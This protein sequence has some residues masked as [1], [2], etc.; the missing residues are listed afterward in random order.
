MQSQS[1]LESTHIE[2]SAKHQENAQSSDGE[3][4]AQLFKY[5]RYIQN[6]YKSK[7]IPLKLVSGKALYSANKTMFDAFAKTAQDN[8]FN[9]EPYIKYCVKCGMTESTLD[10]CFASPTMLSKYLA[11]VKKFALRKKIYRWFMKSAKNIAQECVDN[12]Y[13][14]TKDF[15]RMLIETSQI[16]TYVVAGKISLYF[17]AALPNFKKAIPKLDHFSQQELH[18]LDEHF[19]IYHSE[20]NKAFLQE[21]NMY[22]NPV[23]FTDKLIWK[24]REKK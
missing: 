20:V 13:F 6:P 9:V 19:D 21:K 1:T 10:V 7:T 14:T 4:V 11:H 18:L 22:I 2:A 15:L 5:Y 23:D 3:K 17:F 16:G 12:G 8:K 24:I